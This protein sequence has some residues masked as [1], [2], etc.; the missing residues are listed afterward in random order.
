[1]KSKKLLLAATVLVQTSFANADW[2][3]ADR[4]GSDLAPSP[5]DESR[6]V[7]QVYAAR[8]I[9]WR[10]HFAVHSWIA[11]KEK[12][13]D[14]YRTYHVIGWRQRWGRDIVVVEKT[15]TPDAKWFGNVPELLYDL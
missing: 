15:D 11:T 3:T 2:R 6:A 12:G 13:A 8:V 5:K 10:K 14:H 1:M 9:R 7:V 4:S